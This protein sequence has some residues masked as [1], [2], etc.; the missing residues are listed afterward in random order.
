MPR[1][2]CQILPVVFAGQ[3]SGDNEHQSQPERR[4]IRRQI[5][6]CGSV[7]ERESNERLQRDIA[8]L[9]FERFLVG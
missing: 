6:N 2:F 5:Q 9:S 4:M 8:T 1:F 7:P 3:S